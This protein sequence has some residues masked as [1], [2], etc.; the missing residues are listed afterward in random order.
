VHA[1]HE[2]VWLRFMEIVAALD[3]DLCVPLS[4]EVASTARN[5]ARWRKVMAAVDRSAAWLDI[6]LAAHKALG[7]SCGVLAPIQGASPARPSG[8]SVSFAERVSL[9]FRG[10]GFIRHALENSRPFA[11]LEHGFL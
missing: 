2:N 4:E 10:K 9:Q 1:K 7:L 5:A 8:E 3:P 6:A 11:L